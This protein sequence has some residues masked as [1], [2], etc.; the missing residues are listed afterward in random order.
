MNQEF[1]KRIN[2]IKENMSENN[3]EACIISTTVNMLYAYGKVIIGYYYIPTQG[4]P[5]LF[6]KR[7]S[8]IPGSVPLRKPELIPDLLKERNY[9][10][11]TSMYIEGNEM[12]YG[13]WTRLKNCFPNCKFVDSTQALR[14]VRSIKT[15]LEVSLL[16]ESGR[17][18]VEIYNIIPSLFKPGMSDNDLSIEIEYQMRKKGN[19]G[20]F[21]TFGQ[22]EAFMGSL[23]VGE[24]ASAPSPY[25]FALGGAGDYTLPVG[26]NG[27]IIKEGNSA[28]VDFN[29]NFTGYISDCTR[30]FSYGSLT[31]KAYKAQK[32]SIDILNRFQEYKEGDICEDFYLESLDIAKKNG[33]EDCFMGTTQQAKFVGH[34]VGLVV[35]ELPVLCKKSR[36]ILKKNMAIAVEPKFIIEGVGA[37]GCEDTFIVGKQGTE[38]ITNIDRN[39]IDLTK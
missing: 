25:D 30:T 24:N 9:N 32:V 19:I 20:L 17:K 6:S 38:N 33:L 14:T 5:I 39:I 7:P 13:Y 34:G 22:F 15:D 26:A 16:K 23:L 29:G 11:P 31:S 1:L 2:K 27:S 36:T 21:R 18:Q 28:M 35:N 10:I 8:N 12:G 4:E 37:V 3:I